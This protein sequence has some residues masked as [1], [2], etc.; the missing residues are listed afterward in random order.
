MKTNINKSEL[1]SRSEQLSTKR[2]GLAKIN[3]SRRRVNRSL[4]RETLL[5]VL[6]GSAPQF[7]ELAEVV[8]KWVWIQF[9]DKQ[10]KE[11]TG[12]LAELGFHWNYTRQA[13]QH[14]CGLFRNQHAT[15]DPR[16]VYS[17]YFA[18]DMMLA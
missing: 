4:D 10:P 7:F 5:A 14:P 9:A 6:R 15:F 3:F 11:V 12:T 1:E 13:W 18:A 17:S 16:K 8:G 2:T